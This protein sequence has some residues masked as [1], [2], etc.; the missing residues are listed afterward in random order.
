MLMS[1]FA[2]AFASPDAGF[3]S[4][5]SKLSS[6]FLCDSDD[7]LMRWIRKV[8]RRKDLREKME[9]WRHEWRGFVADGSS[10]SRT[11]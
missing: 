8:L 7:T 10:T 1:H 2:D 6:F 4:I 5:L 11:T 3:E 9:G